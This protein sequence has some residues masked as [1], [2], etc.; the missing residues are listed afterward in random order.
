MVYIKH[1]VTE[2]SNQDSNKKEIHTLPPPVN[3]FPPSPVSRHGHWWTGF[4]MVSEPDVTCGWDTPLFLFCFSLHSY[5]SSNYR[6]TNRELQCEG[7]LPLYFSMRGS[8]QMQTYTSN[9]MLGP[10]TQDTRISA[11]QSNGLALPPAAC[12][13]TKYQALEMSI[14]W[15]KPH[16]APSTLVAQLT[17]TSKGQLRLRV[18]RSPCGSWLPQELMGARLAVAL[19][20]FYVQGIFPALRLF[21]GICMQSQRL[22]HNH[23][24]KVWFIRWHLKGAIPV[25]VPWKTPGCTSKILWWQCL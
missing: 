16:T 7:Y 9:V 1:S 13:H 6:Q 3:K 25:S 22:F 18:G 11:P 24:R 2:R 10:E 12:L 4:V 15:A 20:S 14:Q 19:S 5:D 23:L 8:N 21:S 17:P